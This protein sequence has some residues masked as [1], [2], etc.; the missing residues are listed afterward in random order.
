MGF[1]DPGCFGGEIETPHIDA[2]A[3][4]GLRFNHYTTHPICSP[5]RAA[6]LTGMNAHAVGTGWLANNNPGYPGYSGEIPL[7]AATLPETLRAAGYETIMVGKWHNTPTRDCVPS[8]P[9]HTWPTSRGFDTFYGFMEGEAHFFFPAQLM[10]GNQLVP[11]RRVP[12]GLLHDGRLDRPVDPVLKELRASSPTKPF[13]LYLAHNA[14]HAPLQAKPAD[15][16]RYR[17]RYDAGWTAIRKARLRKQVELGVVPPDTRLPA[18]D[19]RVPP[20][21]DDRSGRP[22]AAG[23]AHGSVCRDARLRRSEPRAAGRIPRRR[24]ASWT[25]RSRVRLGQR[26]HRRGR[27][28]R[29]CSTTTAG[30]WGWRRR[31]SRRSAP[32]PPTWEDRA[33]PRCTRPAGARYR[34]RRSP[35]SRR[36]PAGAAGAFPSSCHGRLGSARRRH[37]PAI[38]A[39]DRCD[40]D[41]ARSF[42]RRA[43]RWRSTAVG[44]A[45]WTASSF[46]RYC[47]TG[48]RPARAPSSTT[49]AGQTARTT[50]TG[51]WRARSRS[52]ASRSTSTTGRCTPESDFSESA[53]VAARSIPSK[54]RAL[55]EAFDAAAWQYFVYPLDNRDRRE[56]FTDAGPDEGA[57]HDRRP[58]YLPGMQTVHRADVFPLI[59]N[60]SFSIR[61]RFAHARGRPG[62]LW[63]IGDPTGGMVLYVEDRRLHFHYNGFGSE[64]RCRPAAARRRPQRDA[65]LRGARANARAVAGCCSTT[66]AGRAGRRC[67]RRWCYTACSRAWTSGSTAAARCLWDLY[68][69]HGAFGYKGRSSDVRIEPSR[70]AM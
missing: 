35:R 57:G 49:N 12:A 58:R 25:T 54:L 48:R 46:A 66:R 17:G 27:R 55:T 10:L 38:R 7:D 61:T 43:A 18:S 50:G 14:V 40:A 28:R 45:P 16:A 33:A 37:P 65:G 9:K 69:R 70:V 11:D 51:G 59:A 5:A 8:A 3:A 47:S 41:A 22:S 36:T 67:R 19:P 32:S 56:K 13:L 42:Q 68:E 24:S 62:V 53:D 23:A 63:A 52:A 30:T 1:S 31:R 44:P 26:R 60:R 39:R 21:D 64:P 4:R 6:L 34:T 29:A 2:L 20:W 15:L